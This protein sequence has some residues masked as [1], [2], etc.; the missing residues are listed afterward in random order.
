MPRFEDSIDVD[1]PV[2]VA[3]EQRTGQTCACSRDA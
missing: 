1:V 2:P 3:Y